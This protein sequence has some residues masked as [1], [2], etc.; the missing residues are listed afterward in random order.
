MFTLLLLLACTPACE[1]LDRE[2]CT[3]RD[4]CARSIAKN[5]CS[6]DQVYGGCMTR[7][8][9]CGDAFTSSF[10]FEGTC[11]TYSQSCW[12]EGLEPC[13]SECDPNIDTG[14]Q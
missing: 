5:Y 2:A 12:P 14:S 9:G 10:L 4:D 1:D 6:G 11:L 7:P 3:A 13:T 8:D